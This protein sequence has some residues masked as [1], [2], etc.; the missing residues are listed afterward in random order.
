MKLSIITLTFNQIEYTKKYIKSLYE[1]T[2]DFELILVD[3]GSTDGTVEYIKSLPYDNI[4]TIFNAENLGFSKGN[5]QGIEIAEGE[6][7]GFLNNDIL[8]SPNW[9]E[10]CEKVFQQENAAFVSPRH[11]NPH[12]DLAK[13]D[14]YIKYFEKNFKYKTNNQKSFDECVFSCVI[15]KQSVVD[16]IGLFDEDYKQAFFEDNDYK[17]RA[18]EA[19]Y[20]VFVCNTV[21][22]FHFGSI[23]SVKLNQELGN[24]RKRYYSKYRFAEYLSQNGEEK[25]KCQRM[26]KRYQVFPLKQIYKVYLFFNKIINRIKKWLRM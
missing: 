20:D 19:K 18:I 24:N 4:K 2:S 14:N 1:Y 26:I 23:T 21:C 16:T 6:Y 7:I 13:E 3:N 12:Y 25:Y 11:I 17:Y 9:F 5:N 15:T 22:F 8:L 10:E